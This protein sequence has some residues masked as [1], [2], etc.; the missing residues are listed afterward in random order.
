MSESV[1]E[2]FKSKT[3]SSYIHSF[4]LHCFVVCIL[5]NYGIDLVI[6]NIQ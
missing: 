2:G 5:F 4:N 3:V 1:R 6:R